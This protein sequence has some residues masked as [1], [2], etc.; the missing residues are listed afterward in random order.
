MF[1]MRSGWSCST[2]QLQ[3]T[4]SFSHADWIISSLSAF[5]QRNRI[6]ACAFLKIKLWRFNTAVSVGLCS[7]M[8]SLLVNMK[9][10]F[11]RQQNFNIK[12]IKSPIQP[13]ASAFKAKARSILTPIIAHIS[14]FATS[15]NVQKYK[16]PTSS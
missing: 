14:V 9:D 1:K 12:D 6:K 13:E 2:Y 7:V 8:I 10:A 15:T 16:P 11:C 5:T 4:I 3:K